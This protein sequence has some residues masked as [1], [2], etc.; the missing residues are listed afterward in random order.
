MIAPL[1]V[2]RRGEDDFLLLTEPELGE[3]VRAHLTR[4]RIAARCEIELEQ[5]T[6]AIVLGPSPTRRRSRPATTAC[7]RSRCSTAGRRR[8]ARR[9]SSSACGSSRGRRAG[10]ARSTRAILP[11]EAGLDQRAVSFTKGCYPG[12]GAVAR[13]HN[14]GHVNRTCAC[15]RS[16]A[17]AARQAAE[18]RL[19]DGW[20]AASRARYPASRSPTFG[21]RSPTTP[22]SRS[23]GGAPRLH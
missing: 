16:T 4:L 20:S 6:S 17:R 2:W 14:R 8:A 12:S 1:V 15:S 13:L 22:S 5:H 18:V 11:A 21:S 10:A 3:T 9:R 7:R 19:G 23:P